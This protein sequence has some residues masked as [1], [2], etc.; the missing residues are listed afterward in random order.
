MELKQFIKEGTSFITPSIQHLQMVEYESEYF[1]FMYG[2]E[3]YNESIKRMYK[4]FKR[5]LWR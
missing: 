1:D 4:E 3:E 2:L 5:K